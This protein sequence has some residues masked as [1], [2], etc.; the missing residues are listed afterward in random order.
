MIESLVERTIY[1]VKEIRSDRDT[2]NKSI[3]GVGSV[4]RS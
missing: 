1:L 3:I 4:G 2:N